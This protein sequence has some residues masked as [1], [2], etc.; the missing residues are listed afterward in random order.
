MLAGYIAE[1]LGGASY[2]DL[3]RDKIFNNIN[4]TSGTF[5]EHLFEKPNYSLPY[6]V[7]NGTLFLSDERVYKYEL[8]ICQLW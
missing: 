4:M 2:E 8:V 3:I 5:M 1:V 7:I 6:E